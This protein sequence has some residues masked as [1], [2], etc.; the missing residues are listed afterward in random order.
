[1]AW[2]FVPVRVAPQRTAGRVDLRRR[3]GRPPTRGGTCP[4]HRTPVAG[5]SGRRQA[6]ARQQPGWAHGVSTGGI[7]RAD[8]RTGRDRSVAG[9]A[10]DHPP[11]SPAGAGI[12]AP[13]AR[14]RA[15]H[16][17]HVRSGRRPREPERRARTGDRG[18]AGPRAGD[19]RCVALAAAGARQGGAHHRR[20]R[21]HR[22]R[23][24]SADRGLP[25]AHPAAGGELRVRAL[26]DPPRAHRPGG[27]P[28]RSARCGRR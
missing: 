9:T 18:P 6:V 28:D 17:R 13:S 10:F 14:A 16:A 21:Q 22:Q 15:N 23:T 12:V 27:Q 24:V 8:P 5:F 3:R 1:M 20:R 11:T 4:R 2:R 26:P 19:A 7:A 25:A